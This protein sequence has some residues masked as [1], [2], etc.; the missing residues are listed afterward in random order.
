MIS[1][2]A[3]AAAKDGEAPLPR[4]SR[5]GKYFEYDLSK[6]HNS[7]GGFLTKEDEEGD[8]I[9]TVVE[10]ARAKERERQMMREGEE[11]CEYKCE[12]G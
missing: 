8:R 7:R 10:L 1:E 12:P 4:D 11:P 9:K 3:T 5:L 2:Q 6:L